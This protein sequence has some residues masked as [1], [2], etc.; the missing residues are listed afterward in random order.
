VGLDCE[1]WRIRSNKSLERAF[2]I[3][4]LQFLSWT[5]FFT[6]P[7]GLALQCILQGHI[8]FNLF[9]PIKLNFQRWTLFIVGCQHSVEW[10]YHIFQLKLFYACMGN[11]FTYQSYGIKYNC[12]IVSDVIIGLYI[13]LK[14]LP[15]KETLEWIKGLVVCVLLFSSFQ[16]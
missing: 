10:L 15:S 1:F 2:M 12:Q 5:L 3:V 7:S 16:D 8:A 13:I 14:F 6:Y 4:L 9:Y 11:L